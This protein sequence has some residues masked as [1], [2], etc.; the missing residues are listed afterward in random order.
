LGG[1]KIYLYRLPAEPDRYVSLN[2]KNWARKLGDGIFVRE[3]EDGFSLEYRLGRLTKARTPKGSVLTF[4]YDGEFCREIRSST[5]APVCVMSILSETT[6]RF[7]SARGTY[8]LVMQEHPGSIEGVPSYTL[9]SIQWPSK[10]TTRFDYSQ[11]DDDVI[12][13]R[14]SYEEDSMEFLWERGSDRLKKADEVNYRIAP[15]TRDF[16]YNAERASTG[17]YTIRREFTDGTWE[18]FLHDEDAGFSD[19]IK[20]NGETLRTRYINTRGPVYNL[21]RKRERLLPDTKEPE[22]FYEAFYDAKGNL[23]RE[24]RDDRVLWHIRKGGIPESVVKKDDDVLRYD[25]S[26]RVDFSRKAGTTIRTSWRANGSRR[27]LSTHP[28][29]ELHLRWLDASGNPMKIPV[30]DKFP[31]RAKFQ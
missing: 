22:V 24:V 27:E 20:S 13:L 28:W 6:R 18:E 21:V 14:M 8:G 16:D 26:G 19:T 10:E 29:G 30:S 7:V 23:L 3:D 2:G 5:G 17:V 4:V 1:R 25:S 31:E 9:A 11:S 12:N 15:L